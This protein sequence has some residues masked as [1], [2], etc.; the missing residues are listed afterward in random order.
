MPLNMNKMLATRNEN[1]KRK[2]SNKKVGHNPPLDWWKI[3]NQGEKVVDFDIPPIDRDKIIDIFENNKKNKII[4]LY[5]KEFVRLYTKYRK[6][7]LREN[8]ASSRSIS[9]YRVRVK[10]RKHAVNGAYFCI[11]HNIHPVDLFRYWHNRVISLHGGRNMGVPQFGFVCSEYAICTI[12][13]VDDDEITKPAEDVI[14]NIFGNDYSQLSRLDTRVRKELL[15]S[16]YGDFG[17]NDRE[18]LSIQMAARAISSGVDVF[19]DEN[20]KEAAGHLAKVLYK[21]LGN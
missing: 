13:A 8:G 3:K 9:M 10:D 21:N 16:K 12:A 11:K 2:Q 19:V 15:K 17:Y 14:E 5:Q 6:A 7:I 20:I 1:K 4:D 18:L